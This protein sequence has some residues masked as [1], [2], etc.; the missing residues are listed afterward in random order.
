MPTS[1]ILRLRRGRVR[2]RLVRSIALHSR[3]RR[4]RRRR[5]MRVPR[6][7]MTNQVIH[8]QKQYL[9][10]SILNITGTP[11]SHNFHTN[12]RLSN[13][14]DA[15]QWE[16]VFRWYRIQRVKFEIVSPFNINQDGVGQGSSLTMYSK[17]E[18]TLNETPPASE[19]AWG[20]IRS[21]RRHEF[22][23]G[24]RR[25]M[26][27]YYKPHTWENPSGLSY[28]KQYNEWQTTYAGG[29][30]VEY[31]G[32]VASVVPT[33]FRNLDASDSM[34]VHVTLYIQFKGSV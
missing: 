34:K 17:R 6:S 24:N 26:K 28:R 1:G 12:V 18:D 27:F 11:T 14:P 13:L 2:R 32:I 20:E 25:I 21:K 31:G 22:G 15:S 8:I 5:V 33:G 7:I 9:D 19:N 10:T 23:G 30:D 29:R 3:S 16:N 4:L